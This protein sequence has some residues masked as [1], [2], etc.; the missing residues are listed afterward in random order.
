M[1]I[2]KRF[3]FIQLGENHTIDN[4]IL[5]K[6]KNLFILIFS[7]LILFQGCGINEKKEREQAI[8]DSVL[9][10]QQLQIQKEQA[11]IDSI[12]RIEQRKALGEINFGISKKEFD[13]L[14]E[15]FK[16][17]CKV[18]DWVASD[19]YKFYNYKI[20]DYKFSDIRG[21][22]ITSDELYS[23]QIL[24]KSV[25]WEKYNTDLKEQYFAIFKVFTN[26]YSYP[27]EDFG[28]PERFKLE[29][30]FTYLLAYWEIGTKRIE[31]RIEDSGT[32]YSINVDIFQPKI[33]NEVEKSN[34]E[35]KNRKAESATKLL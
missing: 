26:K 18:V 16:E 30:G 2:P 34:S 27:K 31:L 32:Y 10:A 7:T 29:K 19:G 6:M 9:I 28:L 14:L 11:I 25:D 12:N 5:I 17:K 35:E 4:P 8:K 1:V 33:R 21:D 20:G 24:G 3:I 15:D 23:I 22:F 13:L